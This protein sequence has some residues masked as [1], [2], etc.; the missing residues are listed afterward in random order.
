MARM[1]IATLCPA[2]AADVERGALRCAA[3][4]VAFAGPDAVRPLA[5]DARLGDGGLEIVSSEDDEPDRVE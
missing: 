4:G 5:L 1:E 3:C 2:C